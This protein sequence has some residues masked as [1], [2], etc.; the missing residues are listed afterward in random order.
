M[1]TEAEILAT[2]KYNVGQIVICNTDKPEEYADLRKG[3]YGT[4]YSKKTRDGKVIYYA[5]WV[6][7]VAPKDYN[8]VHLD[9]HNGWLHEAHISVPPWLLGGAKGTD[10][11]SE[12]SKLAVALHVD[13]GFRMP[14]APIQ[15]IAELG[16]AW[17]GS[18]QGLLEFFAW[19]DTSTIAQ[20]AL[21]ALGAEWPK[22]S[23][24]KLLA[25]MSK[26]KESAKSS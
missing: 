2:S 7:P 25:S 16:Q 9:Q 5:Y 15:K 19:M 4:I 14:S 12:L 20:A 1:A 11:H 21:S 23:L 3:A 8:K 6:N 10:L 22:D 17:D 26:E 13:G 18:V 24:K